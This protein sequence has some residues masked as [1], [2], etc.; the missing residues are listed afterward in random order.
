MAFVSAKLTGDL[1][2]SLGKL[3]DAAGE[4]ALR[5]AGY[6]GAAVFMEEA[7]ANAPV[8]TGFVRDQIIVKRDLSKSAGNTRQTYLVL[9]RRFRKNYAATRANQRL[10]RAG[11][12]N[13]AKAKTFETAGDAF[14]WKFLEYGTQ[15]MPARPFIR[16]AYDS[17]KQEALAVMRLRLWAAIA[18]GLGT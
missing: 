6:A 13:G 4:A 10:G 15:K 18:K 8:D 16:P 7:K 5:S 14:Y 12:N 3:L 11:F 17:K 1:S 9:V 2:K